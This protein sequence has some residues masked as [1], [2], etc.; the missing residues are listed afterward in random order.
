MPNIELSIKELVLL[1][2]ALFPRILELEAKVKD[3][4]DD[5]EAAN[6]LKEFSQLNR[7]L[8][9][10]RLN[11]EKKQ[12]K[13][14][15]INSERDVLTIKEE[16]KIIEL[17]NSRDRFVIGKIRYMTSSHYY[18]QR[19]DKNSSLKVRK[20]RVVSIIDLDEIEE[21]TSDN[22]ARNVARV[23]SETGAIKPPSSE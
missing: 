19:L 8:D 3:N 5:K 20:E 16:I 22:N 17:S 12:I 13:T 4:P 7:K 11:N 15:T 21:A 23:M 18:I 6:L 1:G 14:L 9:Y 2:N 10:V